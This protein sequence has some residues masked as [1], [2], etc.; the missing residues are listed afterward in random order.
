MSLPS[1]CED[2]IK[3]W[4]VVPI[5]NTDEDFSVECGVHQLFFM[6]TVDLMVVEKINNKA[7]GGFRKLCSSGRKNRHHTVTDE[8]TTSTIMRVD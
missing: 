5:Y 4:E 2:H 3:S 7:A 1:E 6:L 8:E